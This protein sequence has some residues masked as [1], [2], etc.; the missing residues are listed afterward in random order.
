[1]KIVKKIK[2][3]YHEKAVRLFNFVNYFSDSYRST[4]EF[5]HFSIDFTNQWT[6]IWS[7]YAWYEFDLFGLRFEYDKHFCGYE[8]EVQL[9]LFGVRVYW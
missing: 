7:K 2:N 6:N 9:L 1:M 5:K 3:S 8:I 4:L